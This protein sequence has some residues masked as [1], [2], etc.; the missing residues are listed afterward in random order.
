MWKTIIFIEK[1]LINGMHQYIKSIGFQN[2]NTKRKIKDILAD[3]ENNFTEHELVSCNEVE[4]SSDYC[5]FR[6]SYGA[7]IGISIFGEMNID[8]KFEKE[9]YFPYFKGTGITS[10][11][12][13]LVERRIEKEAYVGICE[14]VKVGVSL[15]FHLQNSL[16]YMKQKQLGNIPK[17][18]TSL[19]LSGLALSGTI[20]FEI[21]K[22]EQQVKTHKEESRNRM[23]LLSA[24][25]NGDAAAIESLTLDDIDTYSKVS[26]RLIK[27]DI[28]SIV[29]SY[30]MPYGVECDQYSILGDILAME[31]IQNEYSKEEL[32]IFTLD[33]NELI[34]DVCVPKSGIIGEP[35][36]GRRLKSNIWL[37]GYINF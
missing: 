26:K 37:Q 11:A 18:A 35:E 29:D 32:L 24:A 36:V 14:D 1:G 25:R 30:F 15:I 19:T 16:E 31:S 27:E 28:F 13:I 22:N 23:M 2:V 8:E 5:E 20:L 12:D 9:Y 17:S 10:Y 21:K 33:V 3:V 6:K 34:F 7:G 4:E